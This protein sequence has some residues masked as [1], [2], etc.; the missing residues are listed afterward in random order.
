[1]STNFDVIVIGAGPAGYVAA[2]RCAQLGLNTACIDDW[3]DN[4]GNVALGGTCLN[5]GCIP[6]KALLEISE[7]YVQICDE[8]HHPGIKISGVQL[9][10][11]GIQSEKRKIVRQ[12][13]SGISALFRANGVTAISGTAQLQK[14][15]NITVLEK[16]SGEQSE[17]SAAHIIIASGSRPVDIPAASI[18][19]DRIVDSQKALE[20][21]HAPECLGIIGAGVIGLEMGSVWN[22]FGSEVTLLEAQD[23]FL[24]AADRDIAALAL[25]EYQKQGLTIHTGAMV[26]D[27]QTSDE[28]V[29]V[30]YTLDGE[31]CQLDFDRLI[32]AVGR[33]PYTESLLPA[34]TGLLIDEGGF[35][36]V[37][38]N[39]MTN[40]PG[41]YAVGD[42]VNGPMLAHKGM[43]EGAA[44]AEHIA[45]EHST[46]N[47][48]TIP[49][50]IY[51][52]P[53]IAW[54]GMTEE[55][56]RL[57]GTPYRTGS[58]PFS[59]SGRARAMQ[60]TSGMVK[61][62]ADDDNDEILGVHIIGTR[63]SELIAEAVLAMEYRASAEDLAMTIHA[64]PTLS[65]A[66]HEAA[67][68]VNGE[69]IHIV[70]K[71]KS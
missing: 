46:V 24:P 8:A 23:S 62:L 9:D 13:T 70:N 61:I 16:S 39:R 17:Y 21:D 68:A 57:A 45:G 43:A 59:A 47:Y 30:S 26:T 3:L 31:S 7:N 34:E 19:G 12:L 48:D 37:D 55:K 22:R 56:L 14:D 49:S 50:V 64:H 20:F 65:E 32:V 41:V 2:I 67:L 52:E 38:A 44:V 15:R 29:S 6:S 5:A 51:T 18:D 60:Q 63:A 28:S 33:R 53:E 66:L 27:T 1:M 69:A 71:R 36:H 58:F 42:V 35:I 10:I 11:A 25:A 40:L 54:T 4:D